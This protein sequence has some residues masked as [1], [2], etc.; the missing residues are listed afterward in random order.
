MLPDIEAKRISYSL[1]GSTQSCVSL[2]S[3]GFVV[4]CSGLL[5]LWLQ[6]E[7]HTR[8]VEAVTKREKMP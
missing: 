5:C 6:E 1:F 8:D 4:A 7:E 3:I 2:M